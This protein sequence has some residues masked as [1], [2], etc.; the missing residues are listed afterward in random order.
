[1]SRAC[2]WFAK[3]S[4]PVLEVCTKLLGLWDQKKNGR[5]NE[6]E[7]E[8]EGQTRQASSMSKSLGLEF[9]AFIQKRCS[10]AENEPD[11]DSR[12]GEKET[13]AEE[14][15]GEEEEEGRRVS[16]PEVLTLGCDLAGEEFLDWVVLHSWLPRLD[17]CRELLKRLAANTRGERRE[18]LLSELATWT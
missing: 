17:S 15:E 12:K 11:K 1:M 3:S 16:W 6:G 18:E 10:R 2:D 7:E 8:G 14:G 9:V 13:G 4:T 5:S